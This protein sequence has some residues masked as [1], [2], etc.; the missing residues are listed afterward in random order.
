MEP[1]GNQDVAQ[2]CTQLEDVSNSGMK[3][4]KVSFEALKTHS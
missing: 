1:A 2:R 3:A 4:D